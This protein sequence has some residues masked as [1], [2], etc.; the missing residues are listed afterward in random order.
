MAKFTC[1]PPVKGTNAEVSG[2]EAFYYD[3][4]EYGKL[5]LNFSEILVKDQLEVF[6]NRG[7]VK[8][9]S[10]YMLKNVN[11]PAVVLELGFLTNEN[12]KS[13]LTDQEQQKVISKY[14]HKSL[15]E[16]RKS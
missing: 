9:A 12:D 5:S 8:T 14:I 10:F 1:I 11:C 3:K 13:I 2:V 4:N 7:K 16:I 15:M 6:K